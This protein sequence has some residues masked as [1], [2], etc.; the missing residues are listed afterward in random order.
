M[1]SV[2]DDSDLVV[3]LGN[4]LRKGDKKGY[5]ACVVLPVDVLLD[6]DKGKDT[7][8]AER[9]EEEEDEDDER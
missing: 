1:V 8:E 7:L 6:P 2:S 9:E 3:L 5:S 4:G